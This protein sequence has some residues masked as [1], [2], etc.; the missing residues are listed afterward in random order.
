M[1]KIVLVLLALLVSLPGYAAEP[2]T[3]SDIRVEGLERLD[4]GTVFNY[5]PLKVGDEMNDEE[6]R[7]SIKTLFET[8]FFRD[9]QLGQDGTVLVVTVAERPSI[10]SIKITGNEEI[11]TKSLEEGLSKAELVEGRIFNKASLAIVEREVQQAYL[12]MGRYSTSVETEVEELERN[13]VA[14]KIDITEGRVAKIKK[15]NII[16]TNKIKASKLKNEMELI[17]RK[18]WRLFT[19]RNQYSKQKLEADLEI[20]RSYYLDRGFHDFKILS[21]S[22]D[23]SPNKQ[24]IFISIALEEGEQ[25][26][27][28][29]TEIESAGSVEGLE[30]LVTIEPGESFSRKAVNRSRKAI[31]DRYADT[32]YAFVEVR[33]VYKTDRENNTVSTVFTIDPKQRVYVRKIEISGNSYTR[34]EVIRRELRQ[35]EGSWYSAGAVR[36]SKDRLNRLGFFQNVSIETPSVPGTTDQVD[37]RVSV[38]ERDTGSIQLSAGYSDADG[39][40]LGVNYQQRNVLGTGKELNVA[41]NNS[42]AATEASV[43]YT[44]PYYTEDGVSRSISL[45][46]REVDSSE[47]DTAEFILDTT[48]AGVQYKIPI[49]ETNSVNFGV[50]FERLELASTDG[51]PPEFLD[52]IENNPESDDLVLTLGVSKDTRNDFFF[53]T[54]GGVASLGVEVTVPGSDFEY[55][56]VN[57]QGAYYQSVSDRITLKGGFGLGYGDGFGDT[58]EI[59][60]PF[61]KN[62]FAGGSKSVRGYDGRSLGP[63]DTGETPSP[64]GGDRRVLIN[65]EILFP[66]YGDGPSKDKRLGFFVDGGM[67][68]GTGT[69]LDLDMLRYSYGIVFNWL[70]PLGPF[71]LSY[72]EPIDEEPGDEIENFQISFGTVFR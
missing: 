41:L 23:I 26:T 31:A 56:K 57:L 48:A 24:N 15:I 12:A 49:S 32:G 52:I 30:E 8:G 42:D 10:A 47:V 36:R 70:S 60:L 39:A 50:E 54:R 53:P 17:E 62:Y 9:V 58:S 5:L 4:P 20:I 7:I 27:F 28:G 11:E 22:V 35:L 65:T 61:F 44:D 38:V 29:E 55:Y 13:R 69:D 66:P 71:S 19:K 14:I 45:T 34:D 6:A 33:P 63:R 68:Y 2:F 72:G 25:F 40:L 1:K 18:G 64:L 67:V 46:R 51:T 21:S 43:R 16:G 37:L 3:I 59:G